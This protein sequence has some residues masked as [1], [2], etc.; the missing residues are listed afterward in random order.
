MTTPIIEYTTI[1]KSDWKRGAW[2]REPDKRQWADEETG[3]PC[4]IVRGPSGALCGYVGVAPDHPAH[5]LNYD[6]YRT[7]DDGE[8]I[9]PTG[10]ESAIEGIRVHGGLTFASGCRHGDDP[11]KGICHIPGEGEP[12]TVWWFGFDCA[13]SGDYVPAYD[14]RY[15]F[16]CDDEVYRTQ[17]YVESEVRGLARQLAAAASRA[18]ESSPPSSE[19]D[20]PG[21]SSNPPTKQE[22]QRR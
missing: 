2:D 15:S 20:G 7:D 11:S 8:R 4:L 12:D 17:Q 5:G 19:E 3:L 1:D 6:N 22:G 14:R 21:I 16:G 18:A 9:P 10:A 13:H